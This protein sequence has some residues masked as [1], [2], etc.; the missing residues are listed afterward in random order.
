MGAVQ[1][2]YA[3]LS[4]FGFGLL[5]SVLLVYLVLVAPSSARLSIRFSFCSPYRPASW[6]C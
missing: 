5:L 1:A 6:A 3:S 2:M 4:S